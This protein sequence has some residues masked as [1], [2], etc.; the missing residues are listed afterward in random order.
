MPPS[1]V[2]A[3]AC[4]RL[5][6]P[7]T[8]TSG[9]RAADLAGVDEPME[10]LGTASGLSSSASMVPESKGADE[11]MIVTLVLLGMVTYAMF[12]GMGTL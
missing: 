10:P 7:G 6:V 1:S 4:V 11:L 3:A 9:S 12:Y 2:L 8:N 5:A